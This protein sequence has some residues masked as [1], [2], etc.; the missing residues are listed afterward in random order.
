MQWILLKSGP[1]MLLVD[2]KK[3]VF[4]HQKGEKN[5]GLTFHEILVL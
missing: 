1:E 3:T 2:A 5:A 4:K